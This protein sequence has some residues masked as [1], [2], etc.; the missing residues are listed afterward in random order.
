MLYFWGLWVLK[1]IYKLFMLKKEK[2]QE[3]EWDSISFDAD[4]DMVTHNFG[5][6]ISDDFIKL[7]NDQITTFDV[8]YENA[9]TLARDIKIKKSETVYINLTGKFIF[10][11][12]IGAFIQE[13]NLKVKE[14]T[15]VSLAGN[16][17]IYG[18]LIALIERGWVDKLNMVLSE[19]TIA[20]DKKHSPEAVNFLK[21]AL[22]KYKDRFELH[23]GRVH[24]KLVLIETE[25]GGKVTMHGSANLRS[26]QSIEQLII[27]ENAELYDFNYKF[28]QTLKN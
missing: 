28:Y 27:Q 15:V 10:G 21:D 9:A 23:T 4:I 3:Q 1:A 2:Y 11:D 12:F 14:L 26:S 13:N 16:I 6:G 25:K 19:Y 8:A 17:E 18:L 20:M 5:D 7:T 24:A 22:V